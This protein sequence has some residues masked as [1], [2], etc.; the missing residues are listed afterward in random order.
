MISGSDRLNIIALIDESIANGCKRE[1]ACRILGIYQSTYFR[2][3]KQLENTGQTFDLRPSASHSQPKNKLSPA[4]QEIVLKTLNS[5]EFADC[6]PH[7]TVAKLA[8]QGQYIASVSTCY[9]I[10]RS[11]DEAK[12]R[13]LSKQP[14]KRDPPTHVATGINQVWTW[15]ITYLNGPVKGDFY[16]LYMILDIFSRFIVGWEVWPE[17]KA[18]HSI[19]LI[20]RAAFSEHITP[21]SMLVLHS[22]N[23]SPM[24]AYTMLAKLDALGIEPSFSRPHV[25]NDNAYSES[26]FKTCKYRPNFQV[27]GFASLTETREWCHSF[28]RWYNYE[29]HHSGINYLIPYQRH[30]GL[31]ES[32]VQNRHAVFEAAKAAHP[33]RWNGRSTRNWEPPKEVHLNRSNN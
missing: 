8:D 13:G 24:K 5:S 9:R 32:V 14:V 31:E 12:Y 18:E 17:Q 25:S 16:F 7:Q 20:S 27:E 30:L 29:H 1:N 22:D 11:H 28:V 3:K 19:T 23:G 4:E 21:S 15:D 10:L 33:E 2:W 6:S 26:L